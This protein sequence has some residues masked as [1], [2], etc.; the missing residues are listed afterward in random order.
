MPADAPLLEVERL[1]IEFRG[2]RAL[3]DVDFAVPAGGVTAV[4]GPNGAG[5]TTLFNCITGLYRGHGSIRLDGEELGSRAP[6][7]RA[8]LGIARTFQTPTLVPERTVVENVLLGAHHR[9][10]AGM[11][12]SVL[13]RPAVA[14][15]ERRLR[16]EAQELLARLAP[17]L[18]LGTAVPS[19]PHR[20]RRLVEMA[21][22]MLGRPRV[23]L[24]DE[25]AAGSTPAEAHEAVAHLVEVADEMGTTVVLVEH[26]VP[27]VLRVAQRVVVLD[28]GRKLAE[29]TPDEI[30][31]DERV[32]A[33]YLGVS[34]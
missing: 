27:L 23:V 14:A 6:H 21:R 28:H 26:N 4:I 16:A 20:Q 13:G 19:L 1:S 11:L 31:A 32:V 8:A 33:A 25:P 5:K 22:A 9:M 29:G 2:V 12:S 34:A 24:L 18:P 17:D 30:Q 10:R 3:E 7:E 15:E